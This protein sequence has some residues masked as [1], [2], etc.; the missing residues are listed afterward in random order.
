MGL[1]LLDFPDQASIQR[2][3]RLLKV[4]LTP[5]PLAMSM[6]SSRLPAC[7]LGHF[8]GNCDTA[9]GCHIALDSVDTVHRLEIPVYV[10]TYG[11]GIF[12]MPSQEDFVEVAR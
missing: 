3:K 6:L 5:V 9:H 12:A 10:S 4:V 8:F 2:I 11:H 7:T 1:Q